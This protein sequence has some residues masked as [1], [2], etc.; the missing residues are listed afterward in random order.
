MEKQTRLSDLPDELL[1]KIL[2][3]LPMFKVTLATRLISRRWKG[4]WKLV[5]DVTFDDDDIPFKSFET[6][7]SFV[8][9]SFLSNDAQILDRLHLKLNQKYSASD[10]NFWVQ[11]AVNR[12]VRE[13]RI[14]LFGKTL[15]LP[16][17]LCS[18]ITLKELTL[19]DLCIKVVPAWFR[20]PSLKTLHLLSVKFSSDGFVASILR[21]CPVLERLVVDGTKGNV[22]ITNID[23][24]TLRNLSIRNSK[25]KGTYVEGS[26]GFVIKAP[27]LTD[28]NF[29]DTLSNFLMFEPMPEVIKADIQVICDQSKNFIGSLTSIQHLSLCSLTSK[30]PY[31]AC[32]VF[33]SL[34]YLELCTCSARW[35]NLFACILNAA[36]E[37]R[38]LKLKSKHK[39]NYNDPMTLWEEP[40]VVAKCLSEHLE[41]FEWRQYEGTEQERNVA[42]Y[43]L[44]NATCLKMATFSTRCRNRNHRM[45]KKLK[46]MDRVSKACRLVFD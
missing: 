17:C 22:M 13:L 1:L 30:T 4:P 26:K 9:G 5:P 43:I 6:F 7:M 41:I 18:C 37:L 23:V 36:P 3:A 35:A 34:K 10:I 2:S 46:S 38:S 24:P 11:V 25:G 31:P 32:T 27:S 45:L 21:I 29:E 12:S 8:Y 20:L 44:A 42:G 39:F 16:C 40:A 33:S 15:E 14:D 19:H 28:L